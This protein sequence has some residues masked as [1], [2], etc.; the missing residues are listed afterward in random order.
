M[1]RSPRL[2][3]LTA[4]AVLSTPAAAAAAVPHIV[5]PGET[6]WGLAAAQNMTT[7]A[8]AAANDL[9]VDLRIPAGATVHRPT[10]SEAA[11]ALSHTSSAT[12]GVA[13]T[14]AAQAPHAHGAYTVRPGD[15]LSGLAASSRIPV[16]Q[17][18]Q[19]NGLDPSAALLSGTVVKL[20][21]GA[22]A[23]ARAA[24][25]APAARVVPAASPAAAP[26]RVSASAITHEAGH[27]GVPGSLAAAIAWQESGFNNAMVSS[28][29]ARGVMQVMPGTW[30]WVQANLAKGRLD[31]ASPQHNVR[32]GVLYLRSLLRTAGGDPA[33]AAAGYYQGPS[34]VARIGMLPETRR[35]VDNV[36]ALRSRFGG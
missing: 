4:V 31:P 11:G 32:A 23:P 14:T 16:A 10:V 33:T 30:K 18:A 21:T 2:L 3:L 35:Y 6:L 19:M 22:P 24:Q 28:A 12:T 13:T 5:A 34:S 29:N 1:T 25:P 15:T 9:P 26:G 8:F 20:P 27:Q 17:F 7:R 36:L